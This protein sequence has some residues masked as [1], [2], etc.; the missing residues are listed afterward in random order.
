MACVSSAY[1]KQAG[2]E[3]VWAKVLEGPGGKGD[4]EGVATHETGEAKPW[5]YD[6]RL[7][8]GGV[9]IDGGAH[10][11]RPMNML[12]PGKM[13]EVIGVIGHPFSPMEGE[14]FARA[15]CRFDSGVVSTFETDYSDS[16]FFGPESA[17]RVIG[18]GGE[19]QCNPG[20]GKPM[21]TLHFFAV[22]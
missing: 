10:W 3:N 5:R 7:T 6:K 20:G 2:V 22:S 15:L 4:K 16:T 14:S 13:E 18:D 8:G 17:F 21:F 11:L 1:Y 19:I 9:T 12:T